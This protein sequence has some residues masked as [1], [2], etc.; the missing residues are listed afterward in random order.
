MED[1]F[2]D[3]FGV[4]HFNGILGMGQYISQY[5]ESNMKPRRGG[6]EVFSLAQIST[7][8]GGLGC[9]AYFAVQNIA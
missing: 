5:A 8:F 1:C 7:L 3:Y 2:L 6:A 4:V 9:L